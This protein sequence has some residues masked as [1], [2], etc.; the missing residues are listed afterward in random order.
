MRIYYRL[1]R[2]STSHT[3]T[4]TLIFF[5]D[6]KNDGMKVKQHTI[7]IHTMQADKN[8]MVIVLK[9]TRRK[10]IKSELILSTFCCTVERIE[11]DLDGKLFSIIE[12]N[13]CVNLVPLK[14]FCLD[15]GSRSK[16]L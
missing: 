8:P 9:C 3:I 7:Y 13:H 5:D 12:F 11:R 15:H 4:N 2:N 16:A 10:Q 6:K 1:Y 14:Q